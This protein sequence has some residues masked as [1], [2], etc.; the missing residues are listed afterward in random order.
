MLIRGPF[1]IKLGDNIVRDVEELNIEHEIDT[2][3]FTTVQGQTYEVEGPYK[4]T[5]ELTL[6]SSD[7]A[8]LSIL[9]PQ[10]HKANGEVM[11]T[12]ETVSNADGAMEIVPQSCETSAVYNNLDIISCGNPGQVLRLVNVR[13]L[14]GGVE[15]DNKLQR[16]TVRFVGE[17]AG[18]E[19]T[20]QMFKEGTINVVS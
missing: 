12:G 10:Y 3:D 15:L 18:G 16:V 13:S 19:A 7:I 4:A 2:E 1:D 17:P 14:L 6:L 8:S 9:L 20:M 11:S 5:A